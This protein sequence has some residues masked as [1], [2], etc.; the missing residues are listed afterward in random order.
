[1]T[2]Q[3][4]PLRTA[5]KLFYTNRPTN[6]GRDEF[7]CIKY[8]R[9]DHHGSKYWSVL[10]QSAPFILAQQYGSRRIIPGSIGESIRNA[11]LLCQNFLSD[12]RR[13]LER[14]KQSRG[15]ELAKEYYEL[16]R[17]FA[18][19]LI[20]SACVVRNLFHTFSKLSERLQVQMFDYEGNKTHK[21]SMKELMDLLVHCR[22]I[23]FE[24]EYVTDLISGRLSRTAEN[25]NDFMG[26]RF[27]VIDFIEQILEAI[28]SITIKD[29]AT[30]L[31]GCFNSLE[32]S[33]PPQDV[34]FLVQNMESLSDL[35]E[36][37]VLTPEY[38]YF[39]KKFFP[40]SE[41]PDRVAAQTK[42]KSFQVKVRFPKPH[43]KLGDCLDEKSVIIN[44]KAF[45]EYYLDGE[46]IHRCREPRETSFS[47]VE[48]FDQIVSL[49]WDERV[50]DLVNIFDES[51]GF[52]NV[53]Q[54]PKTRGNE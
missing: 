24:G 32:L 34:V 18:N 26:H 29:I 35:L 11:H 20:L 36:G 21:V 27:S 17:T 44:V 48:F 54:S 46:C 6:V 43:V 10:R 8:F 22:Y 13:Y 51:I 28:K 39:V 15:E 38:D 45:M 3:D 16:N 50:L 40:K 33:T 53:L 31:R 7:V 14:M 4:K 41:I 19:S 23:N 1:M 2:S 25:E 47:Y 52:E 42:G 12:Q 5:M 37:V 9:E 49:F 30:R